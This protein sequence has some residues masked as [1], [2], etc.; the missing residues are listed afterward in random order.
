MSVY[1]WKVV[2]TR[3]PTFGNSL[4]KVKI[5]FQLGFKPVTFEVPTPKNIF[6]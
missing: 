6:G 1:A 5:E 3:F 2:K 4:D